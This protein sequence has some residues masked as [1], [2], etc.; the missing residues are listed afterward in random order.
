M[1]TT[2]IF[3]SH[4]AFLTADFWVSFPKLFFISKVFSLFPGEEIF[5]CMSV[6]SY[7]NPATL[8]GHS[9]F[10]SFWLDR[11][12]S[13]SLGWKDVNILWR[14]NHYKGYLFWSIQSVTKI[15]FWLTAAWVVT[16]ISELNNVGN[17][18][19]Y[20]FNKQIQGKT[21]VWQRVLCLAGGQYG[22]TKLLKI[23]Q[24]RFIFPKSFGSENEKPLGNHG[25]KISAI[26]WS[27]CLDHWHEISQHVYLVP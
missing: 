9:F 21:S 7:T 8:N 2:T 3:F 5:Y 27:S 15:L 11:T 23:F 22:W 16:P 4:Q 20:P 14:V 6:D 17:L 12:V 10:A 25:V 18:T 24:L 13:D 1:Y 26:G 19:I